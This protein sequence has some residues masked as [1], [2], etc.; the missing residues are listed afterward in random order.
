MTS[1]ESYWTT[2]IEQFRR[3]PESFLAARKISAHS[4]IMDILQVLGDENLPEILKLQMLFI[5]QEKASNLFLEPRSVES[6]VGSIK[7]LVAQPLK[8]MLE[9][10]R[11]QT[12]SVTVAKMQ[13]SEHTRKDILG[14]S[15]AQAQIYFGQVLV[16]GTVIL[17]T[18]EIVV[19][20]ATDIHLFHFVVWELMY[21]IMSWF[22]FIILV[23]IFFKVVHFYF[24]LYFRLL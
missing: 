8:S 10:Y 7:E 9:V 20:S 18:S 16:T 3:S 5:L 17:I 15:S 13:R 6:A 11:S 24:F 4:F 21:I 14:Q 23:Q 12:P 1:L 2:N 22:N 19:C